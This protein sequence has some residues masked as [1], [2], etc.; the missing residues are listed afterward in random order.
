MARGSCGAAQPAPSLWE[1]PSGA[2]RDIVVALD[3][4][5]ADRW[6]DSACALGLTKLK[7]GD[8]VDSLYRVIRP[9]RSRVYFTEIH[10][11]TWEMLKGEPGF[12][13]LWP[14]FSAFMADA[15]LLVA[16]NASF[17][18]RVLYGCCEAFGI[19]PPEQPFVCTV[20]GARRGLNL[21]HN[22]LNDVCAHLGIELEHHNAASDARAAALIYRHLRVIGLSDADMMLK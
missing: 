12:A 9:P 22:R 4:E 18:R 3:F 2:G 13:E 8:V 11:F 14:Q 21:P 16:H 6:P 10:G 20:K 15:R 5:T 17:D 7:D 19:K 1:M